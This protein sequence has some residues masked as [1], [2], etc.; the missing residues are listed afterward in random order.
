MW[1]IYISKG[2]PLLCFQNSKVWISALQEDKKAMAFDWRGIASI[3]SYSA[4]L[5]LKYSKSHNSYKCCRFKKASQQALL[6]VMTNNPTKYEQIL[7]YGSWQTI[8]PNMNKF[9]HTVSKELHSQII[10]EGQM[11]VDYYYVTPSRS[12]WGTKNIISI[13]VVRTHIQ[14]IY[15]DRK[16]I[17]YLYK[18]RN[19]RKKK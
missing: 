13:L 12:R 1:Y 6:H 10:M 16:Y 2:I 17:I 5:C 3:R 15:I 7:S 8:L 18:F 11:D 9:C 4:T 19:R 14:Y